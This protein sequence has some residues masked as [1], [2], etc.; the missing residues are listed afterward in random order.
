MP[1]MQTM[2]AGTFTPN[3]HA[4]Q[5]LT[6]DAVAFLGGLHERF[7]VSHKSGVRAPR[8]AGDLEPSTASTRSHY[9]LYPLKGSQSS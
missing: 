5:I 1:G 7:P 4:D 8:R 2:A 6:P 9:S 3:S